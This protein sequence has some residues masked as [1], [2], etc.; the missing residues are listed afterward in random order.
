MKSNFLRLLLGIL[1]IALGFALGTYWHNQEESTSTEVN[2]NAQ[3]LVKFENEVK[4]PEEA[5]EDKEAASL[6]ERP[7]RDLPRLNTS[8]LATINLFEEAAPSVCFITTT[9]LR[10]DYFNRNVTEIPRGTGSGFIWDKEGHIVTNYHVIQGADRAKVTLADQTSYE[11]ELIG[12]APTKDL[13]VLKINAPRAK[14]RALPVGFSQNL[15]VGQ[16][17]YA[18]GNPFGLDQTL[19]TGIVSAL[20]REIQSV[21]GIPIREAIQTD[22]AIN[23]GNSGGPLLD[24]SGK[25]IGVNTAIYSPSGAS[26]GIGFSIPVN[27]VRWVVPELI[28]DGR[29][30][31]PSLDV[32]LTP[33]SWVKRYG[34]DGPLVM[35]ILPGGAAE[36]AGLR[37]TRRAKDGDIILGDI[38]TGMNGEKIESY[39]DLVL[40]IEKY[41]PGDTVD[42]KLVRDGKPLTVPII[43][44][45]SN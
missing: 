10:Q 11:A 16:A 30:T 40:A 21:S 32:E 44:N 38:I 7:N 20:G 12:T 13:A 3:R 17:V 14:L 23:P 8:E 1:L 22:A 34:L 33:T 43:L 37:P 25:L 28:E 2:D 24:S 41:K 15:R 39:E 26:A 35:Q 31:R 42:L 45:E 9:N 27:V 6:A 36:Q 5:K 18:I 19:T 4:T 29:I